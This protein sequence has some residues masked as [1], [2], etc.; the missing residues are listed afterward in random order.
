MLFSTPQQLLF[1]FVFTGREK[2]IDLFVRCLKA[3]ED[4][5]QRH[6]LA[7]EGTMGSGKSHLLTELAY[8]GQEAGHRYRFLALGHCPCPSPDSHGTLHPLCWCTWP[9]DCSL[10]T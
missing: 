2:E 5:G 8:L 3:Y 10:T 1:L 9:L 4:F 7:F 6:I